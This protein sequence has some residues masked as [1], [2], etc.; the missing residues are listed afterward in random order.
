MRQQGF[1]SLAG[2]NEL[3]AVEG[4]GRPGRLPDGPS[5]GRAGEVGLSGREAAAI[6]QNP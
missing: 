4:A 3:H 2:G 1:G 5:N 6:E